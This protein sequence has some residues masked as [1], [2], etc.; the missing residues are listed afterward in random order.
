MCVFLFV[1][2]GFGVGLCC[3]WLLGDGVGGVGAFRALGGRGGCVVV[4]WG[5]LSQP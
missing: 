4:C 2:L 5:H 1:F 3:V